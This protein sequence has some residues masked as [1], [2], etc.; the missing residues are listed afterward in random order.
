MFVSW[1]MR[2]AGAGGDEFRVSNAHSRFVYWAIQNAKAKK[3]L[4]YGHALSEYAPKVGD[5]IH[6]NRGHQKI[7]FDFAAAH[8]A[9]E[10]H[11]AAVVEI[12]A[13]SAGRYASTVGGNESDSIGR[14]RVA[15]D[16][17]GFVRQRSVDPYICV[18]ENRET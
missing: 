13:D 18:I 1:V 2:T 11:S 10:S 14:K 15:L 4:F 8:Q 17:G 3:G 12:G 7:S 16:A 5:I 6:N 9:Y